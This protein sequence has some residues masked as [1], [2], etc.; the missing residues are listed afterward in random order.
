MLLRPFRVDDW[1]A[2][3]EIYDLGKPDE[4]RGVLDPQSLLPLAADQTMNAL[5]HASRIVVAEDTSRVVGFAGNRGNFI[6]W[7]FVHPDFRRRG[8]ASALIRHLIAQL[9]WPVTLNVVSENTAARA[10]YAQLGFKVE[11][12]LRGNYQGRPCNVCKL[13]Y[14]TA[15]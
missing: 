1:D 10:L 8:I 2:V 15:A 6:T 5:F 7:L 13:S 14:E 3:C 11:R 12:E 4:M 9:E